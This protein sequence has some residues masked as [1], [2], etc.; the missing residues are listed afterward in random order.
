MTWLKCR[1][2]NQPPA[3]HLRSTAAYLSSAWG[4]TQ[5]LPHGQD[6]AIPL[7]DCRKWP[8]CSAIQPHIHSYCCSNN[9]FQNKW[10]NLWH[11]SVQT[12]LHERQMRKEVEMCPFLLWT[13]QYFADTE[14]SNYLE[15]VWKKWGGKAHLSGPTLG[16]HFPLSAIWCTNYWTFTP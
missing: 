4:L 7:P 10:Q 5:A 14:V 13:T 16:M 6:P 3:E 1:K 15:N 2:G 9:S 12:D 8:S 11:L